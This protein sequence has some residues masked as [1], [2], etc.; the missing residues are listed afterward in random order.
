MLGIGVS[1]LEPGRWFADYTTS[2]GEIRTVQL[3]DGSLAELDTHAALT[4]RYTAKERRVI[5]VEGQAYFTVAPLSEAEHRPFV[6]D[7]AGGTATA[8]GTQF[9][10][11]RNGS[12]VDTTVTEHTVRV[13]REDRDGTL[14][15]V[16]VSEGQSV[17]FSR[18]GLNDP[19]AVSTTTL[20]AWRSGQ[21]VFDN[22]PLSVVIARLNLYRHGRIVLAKRSLA[23]LRVSG[24]FDCKDIEGALTTISQELH[25]KT[26]SVGMLITIVY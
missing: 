23:R 19:H 18:E 8:L 9:M 7:A 16:V 24:V 22:E 4:L 10:V 1:W 5:V 17:H 14:Q 21:L 12:D 15:S 25:V 20:T 11:T 6:V 13:T 26:I 2:T 3:N